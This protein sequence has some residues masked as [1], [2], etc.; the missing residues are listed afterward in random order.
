MPLIIDRLDLAPGDSAGENDIRAALEAAAPAC[1]AGVTW[2]ARVYEGS[3]ID[4][5]QV[6]LE[7]PHVSHLETEWWEE[8][9]GRYVM[10]AVRE[11]EWR[12]A[13]CNSVARLIRQ[14]S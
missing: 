11:G 7:G 2:T 6:V 10:I 14:A 1:A 4:G 8:Q 9:P 3:D 12:T 13:L 5:T